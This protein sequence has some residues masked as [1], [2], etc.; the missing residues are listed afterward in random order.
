MEKKELGREDVIEALKEI[1]F[2]RV[3]RGVELTYLSEPTAQLIRKMDLS[4]VAEFKRNGNGTVEVKFVDRVKALSALYDMLGGGD[5]DEAAEF[6]QALEQAGVTLRDLDAIAVTAGPGLI[7]GV[8]SGVMCAKGLAA[9]TELPLIGVNH[10]AGHALTPRLT[11]QV[12]FP[13]LM[14]LV[15]GGLAWWWWSREVWRTGVIKSLC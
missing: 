2:G 6:L 9:A 8:L 11:D 1:A 5:A 3:N 7:G 13:Y 10:L 4:A 12:S 15:S 14:L